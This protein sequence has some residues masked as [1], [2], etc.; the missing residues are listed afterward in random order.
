MKMLESKMRPSAPHDPRLPKM[1]PSA[2]Q[3]IETSSAFD[4][5]VTTQSGHVVSTSKAEG[6]LEMISISLDNISSVKRMTEA[7][8]AAHSR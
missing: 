2:P 8:L 5:A 6:P 3:T 7:S 1:R 4:L